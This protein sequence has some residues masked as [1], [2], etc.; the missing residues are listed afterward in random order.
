MSE[1]PYW[2][3]NSEFKEIVK[4]LKKLENSEAYEK[5]EIYCD[6]ICK[7]WKVNPMSCA[8]KCEVWLLKSE[9]L[10]KKKSAQVSSS[11]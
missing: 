10:N 5:A 9:I 2:M 1:V 6:I 11:K 8:Y 7:K 3:E 4:R